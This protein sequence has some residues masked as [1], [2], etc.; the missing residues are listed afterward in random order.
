MELCK[1]LKNILQNNSKLS[2]YF[3][4]SFKQICDRVTSKSI[5]AFTLQL[6][7]ERM[8]FNDIQYSFLVCNLMYLTNIVEFITNIEY[9]NRFTKLKEILLNNQF[10][11]NCFLQQFLK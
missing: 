10:F 3:E 4:N 6:N 9:Q 5:L 11:L 8:C 2:D 7:S 1:I